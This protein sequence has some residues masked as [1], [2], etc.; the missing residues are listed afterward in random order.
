MSPDRDRTRDRTGNRTRT[1][2]FGDE[3]TNHEA[4][5]PP[6]LTKPNCKYVVNIII[7]INHFCLMI[8]C[9]QAPAEKWATGGRGGGRLSLPFSLSYPF[10]SHILVAP[11]STR[12][13]VHRL[14]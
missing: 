11:S 4:T 2:R 3:H 5:K 8:A 13:P 14:F 1:A 9:E 7:I 10:S 12:E 6:K